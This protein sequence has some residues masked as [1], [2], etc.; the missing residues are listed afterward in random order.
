MA[1]FFEISTRRRWRADRFDDRASVSWSSEYLDTKSRAWVSCGSIS[2]IVFRT[3]FRQCDRPGSL[4]LL[5]RPEMRAS[6]QMLN[7]PRMS[8]SSFERNSLTALLGRNPFLRALGTN[9]RVAL[10]LDTQGLMPTKRQAQGRVV[11]SWLAPE[12]PTPGTSSAASP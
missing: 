8:A 11:K 10:D 4:D 9:S 1:S 6:D 3:A 5:G 7:C 12:W 2:S